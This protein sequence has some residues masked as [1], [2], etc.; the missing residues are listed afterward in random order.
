MLYAGRTWGDKPAFGWRDV[1]EVYNEPPESPVTSSNMSTY[2]GKTGS[3]STTWSKSSA[4][5]TEKLLLSPYR[6]M[7]HNQALQEVRDLGSGLRE[8]GAGNR[9]SRGFFAIYSVSS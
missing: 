9:S 6:W 7:T 8:L 3:T 1:L 2:S 5:Y 4:K